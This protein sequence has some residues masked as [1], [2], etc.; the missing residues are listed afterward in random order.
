MI[1]VTLD[2]LQHRAIALGHLF[3]HDPQF[4]FLGV[5]SSFKLNGYPLGR[6]LGQP[7]QDLWGGGPHGGRGFTKSGSGCRVGAVRRCL[8]FYFC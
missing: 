3:K 7:G 1:T 2:A 4:H 8:E 5:C 6:L